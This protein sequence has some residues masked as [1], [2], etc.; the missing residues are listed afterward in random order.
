MGQVVSLDA[1][2]AAATLR[3][4]ATLAPSHPSLRW[5]AGDG[6]AHRRRQVDGLSLCGVALTGVAL[7]G[8]GLCPECYQ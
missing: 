8:T 5:E 3:R 6:L 1:H 7:A 2:R 4:A